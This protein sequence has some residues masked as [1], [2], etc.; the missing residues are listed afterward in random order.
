[1]YHMLINSDDMKY[2]ILI[3]ED[4]DFLRTYTKKILLQNDFEVQDVSC[5]KDAL[6]AL[7]REDFDMILLDLNLGDMDGADIIRILRRQNNETPVIVIS[8]F[9]QIDT[10]VN[11][12]DLGCD[13]YITKPFYK[14]ELL[15]RIRRMQKRI[16][17]E[18]ILPLD[19]VREDLI[20]DSFHLDYRDCSVRKDG[21]P[22]KLN[23]KL[24]ELLSYF[25]SNRNQII[26]KEQLLTRF[27]DDQDA[28]SENS[29]LVHIHMLR[30]QIEANPRSPEYL[31]NRR[32]Q[33]YLMNIPERETAPQ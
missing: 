20:I 33:G 28:P 13:D 16:R 26:S 22:L 9:E 15:A 1:M 30:D 7:N 8:N 25:I 27:W 5:G 29:L 12:F 14:E 2:S 4:H 21:S 31:L 10:K 19:N 32:G 6:A 3:V 18:R 11:A 23:R 17:I 24:F